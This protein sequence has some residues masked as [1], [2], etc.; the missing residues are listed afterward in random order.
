MS[1]TYLDPA[2]AQAIQ[3]QGVERC[4]FCNADLSG[5]THY[6]AT[7]HVDLCEQIE[8]EIMGVKRERL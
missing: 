2:T 5:D 6:E 1:V 3:D 7:K 4:V 8:I